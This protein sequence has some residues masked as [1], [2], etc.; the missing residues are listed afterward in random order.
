[1]GGNNSRVGGVDCTQWPSPAPREAVP[2]PWQLSST[3]PELGLIFLK[4]FGK[5]DCIWNVYISCDNMKTIN[6]NVTWMCSRSLTVFKWLVYQIEYLRLTLLKYPWLLIEF[7][8]RSRGSGTKSCLKNKEVE[9]RSESEFLTSEMLR[10]HL[11]TI[12]S[13]SDLPPGFS[14]MLPFLA[15]LRIVCQNLPFP[16]PPYK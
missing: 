15:Y 12:L 4:H 14:T 2:P 13:L 6:W 11:T 5:R 1:M 7:D 16:F 9:R 3:A 8:G 10:A